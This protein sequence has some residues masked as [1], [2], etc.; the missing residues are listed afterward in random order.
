MALDPTKI[1]GELTAT[2]DHWHEAVKLFTGYVA[3]ARDTLFDTLVGN[4]GIPLMKVEISD[5]SQ[6]DYVDTEDLNWL[7]E[8]AGYRI[9]NTDFVIPF[10][11][12]SGGAGSDVTMHKARI[13]L[14][15]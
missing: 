7:Y 15:G 11:R 13:T 12:T 5:V 4:E 2:N 14:L 10:Y 9:Q 1:T 3:P 6:V 8:N